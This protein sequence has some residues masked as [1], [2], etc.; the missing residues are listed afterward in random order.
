MK[1]ELRDKIERFKIKA[2]GFLK[3]DTRAFIV[4]T[5]DT[6]YFCDIVFVGDETITVNCFAG[7]YKGQKRRLFWAD[8]IKLEEY[9]IK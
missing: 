4:D 1:Q 6:Y 2:E 8:V 3:T 9:Q 7:M 5:N